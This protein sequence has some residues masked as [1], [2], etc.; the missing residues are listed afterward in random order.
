MIFL[1][2][3]V[4]ESEMVDLAKQFPYVYLYDKKEL[5]DFRDILN[6]KFDE[7]V[8][9]IL[10]LIKDNNV[11][12]VVIDVHPVCFYVTVDVNLT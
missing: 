10:A 11:K 9:E 8:N 6:S 12:V 2:F 4:E 7:L 5:R 3:L 1:L